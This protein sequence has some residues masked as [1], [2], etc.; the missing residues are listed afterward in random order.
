MSEFKISLV[1]TEFSEV[2]VKGVH[3]PHDAVKVARETRPGFSVDS[4]E[5]TCGGG[6]VSHVL[7]GYCEVCSSP[8]FDW[9]M[10]TRDSESGVI[11]CQTCGDRSEGLHEEG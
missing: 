8:V 2:V 5:E 1:K 7:D 6:C 10:A 9:E 4:V 11:I 3:N